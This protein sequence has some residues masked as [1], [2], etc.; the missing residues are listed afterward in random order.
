MEAEMSESPVRELRLA[1]TVENYEQALA[2]YRDVL[3]LPAIRSWD[4]PSGSGAILDAGRATLEL[5]SVTQAEL[6]DRVEVGERVAGPVRV[7]LEVAD[8][9]ETAR[10]LVAAGAQL[11]AEPVVTPWSHRNVRLRAPDGLQLTLFTVL[12][13]VNA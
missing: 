7:A 8:S 5:L 4:E 9:A 1:V 6:V 12:D 3:G 10:A 11:I 2:F 13:D